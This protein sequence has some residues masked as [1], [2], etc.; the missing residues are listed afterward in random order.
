MKGRRIIT[1]GR[2]AVLFL[3]A[4]AFACDGGTDPDPEPNRPPVAVGS[5]PSLTLTEGESATVDASQFFSDP[6][7]DQLTYSATSSNTSVLTVSVSG[8]N[9]TANALAAGTAIATVTAT[10]PDGL[11][12]SHTVGVNVQ[13]ANQAPVVSDTIPAQD[14]TEGDTVTIDASGHFSDP[15][16]DALTFSAASGDTDVATAAVDGST[17]TIIAVAEGTA[18]VTVTATDPEGASAMQ[19][20][21]VTVEAANRA[22]VAVGEIPALTLEEGTRF[23]AAINQFFHD[24]DGDTLTYVPTV[25]D[26]LVVTAAITDTVIVVNAVGEGMATIT[27][28]ATDPEGL[29]ATQTASI[30]VEGTNEGPTLTDTLQHQDLMVGDTLTLDAAD[31]F[32]DPDGDTLTFTVETDDDAV[33]TVSIDGSM[34]TVVAVGPGSAFITVTAT[35]P[36][37]ASAAQTFA[38]RVAQGNRA[39][40]AV[41]EIPDGALPEG[42]SFTAP[43]DGFFMDPDGDTLT[44]SAMSSDTAVATASMSGSVI[45]VTAVA[46]G[47]AT[48]TVTATDPEGLSATQTMTLTVFSVNQGPTLTDTIPA[49]D[50]MPGD[51]ITLDLADNFTDPD[52]DTLTFTAETDDTTVATVSIDGSM[53]TVA[54]VDVGT[55]F[56]TVAATDPDGASAAQTFAAFVAQGNR[57][58]RAVG[59]IAAQSVTVDD[60]VTVDVSGN[61]SDPD[62]DALTYTAA[63]SDDATAAVSVSG[64]M[65]T[66]TGVAAGSATVTVTA[67]DP[68]G[69]SAMQTFDVTVN[70]GNQ[71]PEI[72]DTIPVHDLLLVLDSTDMT[73]VDTMTSVVLDMADFF[74]DP[75]DDELTYTASVAD[76]AIA[77]VESVEGSVVTT[78]AVSSDTTTFAHDTTMLTV[79]ATD[80]GGLSVSQEVAVLVANS[81]YVL[82]DL[83][84]IQDEGT[85]QLG[86]LLTLGSCLEVT[87]FPFSGTVYT[88]HWTA[89]QVKKGT[90]WV[91]LPGTHK[92]K[93][94]CPFLDLPDASAGTYRVV[95]ELTTY[96][97]GGD[98]ETESVLDRRSSAEY[99]K[100]SN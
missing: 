41:G 87:N 16:G 23:T 55:A 42:Q 97:F 68:G 89:W 96:P 66:V 60:T 35:D 75:D 44:Y 48:I 59:E 64:A 69:L 71:G 7:G 90:G 47:M 80:P 81:D 79:T 65:V 26:T 36:D 57:A 45:T 88:V 52:G 8:S 30:T 56:I 91:N 32:T 78:V 82:W 15:D 29:S 61:F 76:D 67:T 14:L 24:P 72:S 62:D 85:V 98:P 43:V 54:A 38:A 18:T 73:M 10:D 77:M 51:T 1:L 9:V 13:S 100:E 39:P 31:Y 46:E 11:S 86:G 50:M 33:A 19:E 93:E 58:P 6:D 22:P 70:A 3:V 25:S 2:F 27:I 49:Q 20:V 99:V 4:G 95:G 12:A 37:G 94:I 53:V 21:A 17:V 28:T 74:I 63:S 34:F 84:V 83:I 40:Q 92:E 5:I